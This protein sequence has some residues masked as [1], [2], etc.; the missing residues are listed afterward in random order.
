MISPENIRV[1]N[2][3][4]EQVLFLYSGTNTHT[5]KLNKEKEAMNLKNMGYK[6]RFGGMKRERKND[7]LSME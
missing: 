1:S 5:H 2:I 4:N 3:Q 6:G 7:M